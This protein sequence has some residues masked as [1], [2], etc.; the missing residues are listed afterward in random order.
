MAWWFDD[1][2]WSLLLEFFLECGPNL[3]IE[4]WWTSTDHRDHH[5]S[6]PPRQHGC[7]W[8]D[9]VHGEGPRISLERIWRSLLLETVP[10]AAPMCH[11][12]GIS[13]NSKSFDMFR[14]VKYR[15]AW[16]LKSRICQLWWSID[17]SSLISLI[18]SNGKSKRK[19][20]MH[21]PV[22]VPFIRCQSTALQHQ[23]TISAFKALQGCRPGI[24]G[25]G[26]DCT[27]PKPHFLHPSILGMVELNCGCKC[28]EAVNVDNRTII[29]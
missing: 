18:W 27:L 29:W 11:C 6:A 17:W 1:G 4:F 7:W 9:G 14:H 28:L 16:S 12:W 20:S 13:S 26:I 2:W 22:D 8:P 19:Y 21:S 3:G 24:Q 10:H 15:W 25:V 23:C 5:R